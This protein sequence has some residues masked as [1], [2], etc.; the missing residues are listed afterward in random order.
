MSAPLKPVTISYHGQVL[1][2]AYIHTDILS[3]RSRS[4]FDQYAS[5]AGRTELIDQHDTQYAISGS[6]NINTDLVFHGFTS[7]P[8]ASQNVIASGGLKL[9][10]CGENP[11]ITLLGADA[12]VAGCG[13]FYFRKIDL[14]S[15]GTAVAIA[16]VGLE[17]ALRHY[18]V[19]SVIRVNLRD[20]E[21]RC[22]N[23][24]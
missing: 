5:A 7:K 10:H 11:Q 2:F 21:R 22:D 16:F 13:R 15:K 20:G 1:C 18:H 12:T 19:K 17:L 24:A 6:V 9:T 8:I 14:K 3:W 23:M 4:T